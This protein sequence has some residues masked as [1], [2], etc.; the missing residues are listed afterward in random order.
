MKDIHRDLLFFCSFSILPP[1]SH[2]PS[3]NSSVSAFGL[4]PHSGLVHCYVMFG[5]SQLPYLCSVSVAR[6]YCQKIE[7]KNQTLRQTKREGVKDFR[8][9]ER[10][11]VRRKARLR[12][13]E[14]ET[15]RGR[16]R[17]SKTQEAHDLVHWTS[18]EH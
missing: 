1:A 16:K 15:E 10:I 14:S 4:T 6:T 13:Q 18:Q 2:S 9:N 5:L 8:E 17:E 3:S 7:R 11:S 12:E